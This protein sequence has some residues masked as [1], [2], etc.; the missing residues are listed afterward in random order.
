MQLFLLFISFH[1][2]A[3]LL[4]LESIVDWPHALYKNKIWMKK[5]PSQTLSKRNQ[6]LW[7]LPVHMMS[8]LGASLLP[9]VRRYSEPETVGM[10]RVA[11][12]WVGQN[13]NCGRHKWSFISFVTVTWQPRPWSETVPSGN[14]ARYKSASAGSHANKVNIN[15][16]IVV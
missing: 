13:R 5:K 6:P 15:W 10:A 3:V 2:W 1:K 14:Q 7:N 11:Q 9:M 8:M 16:R 12:Y 4:P